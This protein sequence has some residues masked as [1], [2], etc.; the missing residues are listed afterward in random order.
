MLKR[1]IDVVVSA[2]GLLLAAPILV[3]AMAL[4]WLQDFRS[5]L[6]FAP[7]VGKDGRIFRMVKLRSMVVGADRTGI[8][9]TSARDPRVT[10]V[11]RIV[12]RF[13]LDELSQFWNVLV[14][15]MSLVGP[16]P[17]VER[18]TERYTPV[19]RGLLAVTPGITDM[20][21]IVFSDLADILKESAD[22]NLD[23]NQLVRPWK[24]RLGLFYI[25]NRSDL[26][27]LALILLTGVALVSR[28][29]ALCGIARLLET[30]GASEDLCRV[31]RRSG[32]LRPC[33]PPGA[34]RVVTEADMDM[35]PAQF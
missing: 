9:S 4:I 11:G 10:T 12:R 28:R 22:P 26:L 20:A 34:D 32:S 14:G 8:D 27:D 16:R 24:S 5:P 18:E 33:A 6:Y 35:V 21:S 13:K 2:A 15:D 30:M 7:R 23:Y 29:A 25:E 17:N 1:T 3:P 19:E 31:A